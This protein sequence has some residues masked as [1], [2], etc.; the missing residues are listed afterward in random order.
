MQTVSEIADEILGREGGYVNDPD[1]PGGPTNFG[2][3]LGTL[4]AHRNNRRLTA[5]DVANLTRAEAKEILIKRHYHT[6]RIGALPEILRG[7][8]FDMHVNA[9]IRAVRILQE[10][11]TRMGPHVLRADGIIGPKT[12]K[13]AFEAM[14]VSPEKLYAAYGIER[15]NY[16][17]ALADR[18]PKLRKFARRR[19]G[20]K[21]GWIAR[22]ED[23][24]P[25]EYHLS[26]ASHRA[27][28]AA[29]V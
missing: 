9:G 25:A 1:D 11:L 8:V 16:Y 10:L 6:P 24:I 18:A 20:G 14:L 2:V 19:D 3:T 21:G 28:V 23:F 22:A 27:R 17:Y 7:T 29:W 4:R 12:Q 13:A 26:E 5:R 15:R